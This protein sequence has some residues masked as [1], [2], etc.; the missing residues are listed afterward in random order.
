[1]SPSGASPN[2]LAARAKSA[3]QAMAQSGAFSE[4]FHT[5]LLPQTHARAAF[6]DHTATGKLNADITPT[7]PIG[8]Q[9]SDILWPGRSEGI[10]SP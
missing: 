10:V 5:T 2:A 1:M 8:C 3:L 4:G 7:T 9:N 6:Q